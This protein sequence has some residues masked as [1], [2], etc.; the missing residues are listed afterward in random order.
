MRSHEVV[1]SERHGHISVHSEYNV[2][3]KDFSSIPASLSLYYGSHEYGLT[4]LTL[5]QHL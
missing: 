4:K 1:V 2:R 5:V 3:V